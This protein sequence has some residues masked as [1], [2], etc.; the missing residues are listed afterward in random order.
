[1]GSKVA[2]KELAIM[3]ACAVALGAGLCGLGACTRGE[4]GGPGAATPST[5]VASDAALE[6][7][8][9]ASPGPP[10]DHGEL[11]E[12]EADAEA[13]DADLTGLLHGPEATDLAAAAVK[14]PAGWQGTGVLAKRGERLPRRAPSWAKVAAEIIEHDGQTYIASL[15]PSLKGIRIAKLEWENSKKE[16]R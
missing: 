16:V 12:G 13:G 6:G 15:L 1:M 14:L 10:A 8:E 3:G 9:P 5:G 4:E 11:A 7:G 2:S